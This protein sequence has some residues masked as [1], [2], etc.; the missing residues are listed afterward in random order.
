MHEMNFFRI[1]KCNWN[2]DFPKQKP[3]K[4][5]LLPGS[6]RTILITHVLLLNDQQRANKMTNKIRSLAKAEEGLFFKFTQNQL[7]NMIPNSGSEK[8]ANTVLN[9]NLT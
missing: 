8:R 6:E 4:R 1:R 7:A 5:S 2:F 9:S 3:V